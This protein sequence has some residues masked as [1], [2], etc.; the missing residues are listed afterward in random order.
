MSRYASKT[1]V[2]TDKSQ[3][4]IKRILQRYGAGQYAPAEDWDRGIAMIGFTF[5]GLAVRIMLQ[6]P[7]RDDPTFTE[8]ETGRER[9][10]SA[11]MK[12]WEQA[13]RQR[14]RA[15]ALVVKAKLEAV[16]AGIATFEQEFMSYLV[17]PDGRTA[18]EKLLPQITK[19]IAMGKM[20]RALPMFEE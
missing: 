2:S 12:A 19:G 17:L 20:P 13:C 14:W 8:T 11:A 18:G 15:L 16:E 10:P 5:K 1:Q 3:A 7:K 6:L 9:K 4:E